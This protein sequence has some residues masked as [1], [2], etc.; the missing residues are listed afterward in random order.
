MM[1]L[2]MPETCRGWR[3]IL[4]ISC[5]SSWFFFTQLYQDARSTKHKQYWRILV[6]S[7]W[8]SSS[9][10]RMWCAVGWVVPEIAKDWGVL[11]C[12]DSQESSTWKCQ[13]LLAEVHGVTSKK[14]WIS[15]FQTFAVFWMLFAFFWVIPRR[16][17]FICRRFGTLC[18]FHLHRF[19]DAVFF[20]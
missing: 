3:N 11:T 2:D 17:S 18:L 4:R 20:K 6:P 7:C 10:R 12:R 15:W 16:L 8:R 1:G 14:T 19:L 5:A 13:E 9:A